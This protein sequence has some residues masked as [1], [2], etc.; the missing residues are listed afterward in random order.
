MYGF[1]HLKLKKNIIPLVVLMNRSW[2]QRLPQVRL[3]WRAFFWWFCGLVIIQHRIRTSLY[4]CCAIVLFSWACAP[5]FEWNP[6]SFSGP[7]ASV[8]SPL[9]CG[10]RRSAWW[11]LLEKPV[12]QSDFGSADMNTVATRNPTKIPINNGARDLRLVMFRTPIVRKNEQ[13]RFQ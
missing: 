2:L 1:V 10:S 9:E 3:T 12:S 5:S 13:Y 6:T 11:V 8:K 4:N 7:S